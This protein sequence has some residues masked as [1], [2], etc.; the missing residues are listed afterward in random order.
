SD[1][2]GVASRYL[3]QVSALAASLSKAAFFSGGITGW[4]GRGGAWTTTPGTVVSFGPSA[5]A[6]AGL[7]SLAVLSAWARAAWAESASPRAPAAASA[8]RSGVFRGRV[9]VPSFL[10][11]VRSRATGG[12]T[13]GWRPS[14]FHPRERFRP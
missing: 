6:A 7:M 10:A 14:I 9:I 2:G 5:G 11:R 1:R 13:A 12:L 4:S 3:R 8:R